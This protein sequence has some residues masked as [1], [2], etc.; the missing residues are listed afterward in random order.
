MWNRRPVFSGFVLSACLIGALVLPQ[1]SAQGPW[2]WW[3][4]PSVN[5]GLSVW[6][7]YSN[8]YSAVWSDRSAVDQAVSAMSLQGIQVAFVALSSATATPHLQALSNRQDPL[9]AN[10]QYLLDQ[11]AA[12]NIGACATI[13]SDD[14][15][16]SSD[17]MARY[18]LVDH[19][20]DFNNSLAPGDTGFNCVST[21]LEMNTGSQTT[22]VYDM[23]KQFHSNLRAEIS[24]DGGGLQLMAWIQGPDYLLEK[25]APADRQQLMTREGI[26]QDPS[27]S[28]LYDG[29]LRY[30]TTQGGVPIF[31]AVIP[32]WYYTPAD[33]YYA[34]LDH[35]VQELQN[36]G[37]SSLYLIAGLMVQNGTTGIC[38]SGC[39][40]SRT[41]YDNRLSYNDNVRMQFP[42][43]I[44]TGVFLWPIQA[45]WTCP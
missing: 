34:R 1:A 13:L 33:S 4:D 7:A 8:G 27:D 29:A 43:Y 31:D 17:Q 23:W 21:D 36:M 26:T 37:D 2:G 35:N 20:A 11:L 40:S 41:D 14:F 10:V 38:C 9:T 44:G 25:M 42:N 19:L 6:I 39:V 16:G 45:S 28:S 32:M 15:T 5:R 30:F 3:P 22:A 12:N 24:S 18:V